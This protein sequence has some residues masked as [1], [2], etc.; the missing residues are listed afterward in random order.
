MFRLALPGLGISL[1]ALRS[2]YPI[3]VHDPPLSTLPSEI[4]FDLDWI[5]VLGPLALVLT[6]VAVLANRFLTPAGGILVALLL[7]G[8]DLLADR[9]LRRQH[10]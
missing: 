8:A 6:L 7:L 10:G 9:S 5:G 3:C 4:R 2:L 1:L